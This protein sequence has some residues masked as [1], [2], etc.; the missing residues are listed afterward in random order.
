MKSNDEIIK[1]INEIEKLT[2]NLRIDL[3]ER[4]SRQPTGK[5]TIGDRVKILNPKKGQEKTG[6][7]S[8]IGAFRVTIDTQKG[9]VI[10]SFHNLHRE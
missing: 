9:K 3:E 6:T 8:K 2:R 5:L 4:S 1:Q 10:R 7:V